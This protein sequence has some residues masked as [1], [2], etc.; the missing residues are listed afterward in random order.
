MKPM[1][2]TYVSMVVAIH[3]YQ[4]NNTKSTR[5]L[6]YEASTHLVINCYLDLS[7]LFKL[8]SDIFLFAPL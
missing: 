1:I 3:G 5:L 2:D 7:L 6:D 4:Y 8:Q